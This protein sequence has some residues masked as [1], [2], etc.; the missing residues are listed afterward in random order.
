MYANGDG[1]PDDEAEALAWFHEAAEEGD[2]PAQYMH[3]VMYAD[4]A[5]PGGAPVRRARGAAR[6]IPARDR[7]SPNNVE[8]H[9][10]FSIAASHVTGEEQRFYASI[11]DR[12][13][14]EMT[15]GQLA[16]AQQRAGEW[17][18]GFEQRQAE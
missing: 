10:W 14:M 5:D 8:A 12:A 17:Q 11:R 3:G 13:A 7:R 18:A 4:G 6:G 15:P 16:E 1:V 9:K 2:V